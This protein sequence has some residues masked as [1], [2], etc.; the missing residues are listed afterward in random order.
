MC[1]V[2]MTTGMSWMFWQVSPLQS[3]LWWPALQCHWSRSADR[4]SAVGPE[5][6]RQGESS[7]D[8]TGRKAERDGGSTRMKGWGVPARHSGETDVAA[9][10]WQGVVPEEGNI[11]CRK[12]ICRHFISHSGRSLTPEKNNTERKTD[13]HYDHKAVLYQHKAA[14]ITDLAVL[15]KH[16]I[17]DDENFYFFYFKIFLLSWINPCLNLSLTCHTN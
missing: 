14:W 16:S 11:Q 17:K 8:E 15:N 9:T 3:H 2:V 7:A 1:C 12:D 4:N 13:Q 6:W 10:R 5:R